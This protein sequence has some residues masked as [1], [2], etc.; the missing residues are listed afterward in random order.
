[1]SHF[2]YLA[3]PYS[4]YVGGIEAAFR[5]AAEQAAV[6]LENGV[7]VYSPIAHS[8][9]IAIYGGL[10]PYAHAL[11]M[12]ACEPFM[13]QAAGIVVLMAAGW[14]ESKGI[15]MEIEHFK[16]AG[17]PVFFMLPNMVPDELLLVND[18]V[19]LPRPVRYEF[20]AT[21][22]VFMP[23]PDGE[24]Y[25]LVPYRGNANEVFNQLLHA[26]RRLGWPED[27]AQELARI[28]EYREA[29]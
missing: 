27:K 11:W 20:T 23:H 26:A 4:K 14:E 22:N 12:K 21:G 17:K 28:E 25:V 24:T 9:P 10:D 6:L 7:P 29:S 15:G 1:M 13:N 5:M 16:K 8:H 18:Q 3:T 19:E 2:F